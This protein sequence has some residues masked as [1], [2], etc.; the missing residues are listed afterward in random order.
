M[1]YNTW[2]TR[3]G[4]DCARAC[5]GRPAPRKVGGCGYVREAGQGRELRSGKIMNF[6]EQKGSRS[7]GGVVE[8]G[9]EGAQPPVEAYRTLC[10]H[11]TRGCSFVVGSFGL[12]Q[13]PFIS[14]SSL[15]TPFTLLVP[16]LWQG[17]SVQTVS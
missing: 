10:S 2:A 9:E 15:P 7:D 4:G 3:D 5:D 11:Y 13:Y 8:V 17:V 6:G 16:M 1:Y 12:Y 14:F